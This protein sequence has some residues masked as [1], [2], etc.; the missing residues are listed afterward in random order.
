MTERDPV[1]LAVLERTRPHPADG[2]D[3]DDVV[4]RAA[5]SAR[6]REPRR[7]VARVMRWAPGLAGGI[8]LAAVLGVMAVRQGGAPPSAAPKGV[9]GVEALVRVTSIRD[10]QTDEQAA[11]RMER[12]LTDRARIQGI[13]GFAI[14]RS[15]AE[16]SVF[17][18]RTQNP[19]WV[20][21]WIGVVPSLRVVDGKGGLVRSGSDPIAVARAVEVKEGAGPVIYYRAARGSRPGTGYVVGPYASRADAVAA[22]MP[23]PETVRIVAVAPRTSLT[24][25]IGGEPTRFEA[26][27]D[28]LIPPGAVTAVEARG[29]RVVLTIAEDDRKAFES[30]TG[31]SFLVPVLEELAV[32]V[33]VPFADR[34]PVTGQLWF[35]APD[36]EARRIAFTYAGGQADALTTTTRAARVGPMPAP[37]G[38]RVR[39]ADQLRRA[40][41]GPGGDNPIRW[42]TF[43]RVVTTTSAQGTWWVWTAEAA[44]GGSTAGV[45]SPGGGFSFGG[46]DIDPA[47]PVVTVC[48]G[49]WENAR[50]TR[51]V[52]GRAGDAVRRVTVVSRDGVRTEARV[53]NGFYIAPVPIRSGRLRA[54]VAQDGDGREL[55]RITR[56]DP[57]WGPA[58]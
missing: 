31:G 54:I 53:A 43:R 52:F 55:G 27:R 20:R 14:E 25:R 30:R 40:A 38:R 44:A 8:A 57:M 45:V 46:C 18:P 35:R 33:R 15:G 19:A 23:A 1:V 36:V 10:G 29:N 4:R 17:V 39:V 51:I 11:E 2:V 49:A 7:P 26:R 21:H 56:Q 47:R 24:M 48:G 13:T 58:L 34:D 32:G 5:S 16:L 9:T 28:G 42:S 12:V 22:G 37:R 50:G 6:R 41:Q 3:W